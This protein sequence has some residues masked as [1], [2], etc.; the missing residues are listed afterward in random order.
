MLECVSNTYQVLAAWLNN[1]QG[2]LGFAIFVI[3]LLLGWLSGIF[4]ALR[5]RPKFRIYLIEGPTFCCTFATGGKHNEVPVHRTGVA[6]YLN[7]ANVGSAPSSI[8]GV[9]VGYHI[10]ARLFSLDWFRY[11]LGWLWLTHQIACIHDFQSQIGESV[12]VYPFLIQRSVLSGDS[13]DTYLQPGQA[14]NGVVYFEQ[15]DSWGNFSPLETAKGVRIKV[16]LSDVFGRRHSAQFYIE[17]VTMDHARE[18]NPSFG[19]TLAELRMETLLHDV[20]I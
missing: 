13:A 10:P 2:V 9:A 4:S 3:T 17:A 7:V 18:Y 19:K 20:N 8:G 12:K 11:R 5:R 15:S 1:N 16:A 6:L 14:A